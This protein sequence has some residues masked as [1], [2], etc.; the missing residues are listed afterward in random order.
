MF[1]RDPE[2][3]HKTILLGEWTRS[4]FRHLEDL[5][6]EWTEKI[7]GTNIRVI[8]DTP[9]D[10]TPGS[11]EFRG[12]SDKAQIPPSLSEKLKEMFPIE[13]FYELYNDIP[14]C[15]YG[16]GYGAKI[17]KGGGNY[18]PDGVSFIAFDVW[19]DGVWLERK[20]VADIAKKL[21]IDIAPI[22][23]HGSLLSAAL[24]T[25]VGFMSS[26]GSAHAEGLVIRP[27]VGLLDRMGRRIITK[28]KHK[29]FDF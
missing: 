23:A 22:V 9:S 25:Q 24:Y 5:D 8:W 11:L 27:P 26:I 6:W 16:E 14:M 17:Q 4:E 12:K 15:I 18:I 29:D 28:I 3:N 19:V 13:K 21:D 1:K 7:D 20:N 10:V 2:K